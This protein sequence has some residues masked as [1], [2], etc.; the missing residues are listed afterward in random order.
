MTMGWCLKPFGRMLLFL[1]L[2]RSGDASQDSDTERPTMPLPVRVADLPGGEGSV[3]PSLAQAA[4]GDLVA[5]FSL[6]SRVARDM[7]ISR[8]IDGGRTWSVP[9]PLEAFAD[10]TAY[11]YPGALTRLK[12]GRLILSWSAPPQK[13]GGRVP[14]YASSGDSGKTWSKPER[15]L[16]EKPTVH[17]THRYSFLELSPHDWV[18]PLYDRT[19]SYDPESGKVIPFGD[20]RNHGMVPLVQTPKGTL[21]SGATGRR[22]ELGLRSSDRGKTWSPLRAFPYHELGFPHDLTAL[23]DG[24]VV[25]T[26]VIYEP[27]P[28][29]EVSLERGF[30]LVVSHDDGLTWD[31]EH[32]IE[33]FRPAR[34]VEAA[35]GGWPRTVEI[36]KEALGTLFFNLDKHQ[37]GGPGVFFIRT[38]LDRLKTPPARND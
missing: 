13:E 1:L 31:H 28:I 22:F 16:P 36:D 9:A 4:N 5:V 33:I 23:A 10:P 19:V 27:M 29:D 20:G 35:R 11:V 17:C 6:G 2:S 15:I 18:F 34:R 14:W 30:E 21:V 38:A 8:S 37:P 7:R 3:H 12:D 32:A 26:A 25:L 24:R